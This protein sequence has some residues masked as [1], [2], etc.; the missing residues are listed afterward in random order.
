MPRKVNPLDL[1]TKEPLIERQRKLW[2]VSDAID[3]ANFKNEPIPQE[4][5]FWLFKAFRNIAFGEDANAVFD[6]V[7]EKRGVRKTSFKLEFQK[8][9]AMSNVAAATSSQTKKKTNLALAEATKSLTNLKESS[10]RKSWNSS[11]A[12][13][14]PGFTLS[15]K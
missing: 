6:V 5:A 7:P 12:K 3:L 15:K 9:L 13:R 2:A 11:T 4:L 14:T 10:V 1:T 8:N